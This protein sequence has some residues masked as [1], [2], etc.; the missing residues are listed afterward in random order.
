[1]VIILLKR[2]LQT[3]FQ[4]FE[5][6]LRILTGLNEDDIQ[7]II[8]QYNSI[9]TTFENSPIICSIKDITEVLSRGFIK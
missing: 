1:M 9:F 4:V 8:K 2:Y 6:Y 7:L 5:S 3:P